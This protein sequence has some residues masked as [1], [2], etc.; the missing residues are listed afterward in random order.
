MDIS[1]VALELSNGDPR[2]PGLRDSLLAALER[3]PACRQDGSRCVTEVLGFLRFVL[4][5]ETC[6]AHTEV[7][8][9]SGAWRHSHFSWELDAPLATWHWLDAFLDRALGPRPR[10]EADPKEEVRRRALKTRL[11]IEACDSGHMPAFRRRLVAAISLDPEVRWLLDRLQPPP[12]G[13]TSDDYT[14]VWQSYATWADLRNDHEDLAVLL[15]FLQRSDAGE[16]APATASGFQG[17]KAH[18]LAMKAGRAG[19]QSICRHA[20]TLCAQAL[21]VESGNNLGA[22]VALQ[23]RLLRGF[24][25]R[26]PHPEIVRAVLGSTHLVQRLDEIDIPHRLLELAESAFAQARREK[27]AESF[28]QEEWL[29]VIAWVIEAQPAF[30]R[31]QWERGWPAILRAKSEWTLHELARASRAEWTALAAP[32][33]LGDFVVVELD[34]AARL[35]VE[36]VEM[37]HCVADYAEECISGRTRIFSLARR[38]TGRRVATVL[39]QSTPRGWQVW[40]ARGRANAPLP[41]DVQDVAKCIPSRIPIAGKQ[42]RD[43]IA[44]LLASLDEG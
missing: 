31:N 38:D 29:P 6:T 30:H 24:G 19:W 5:S 35:V 16:G 22:M 12:E 3:E 14:Q 27:N 25:H 9:S 11:R 44:E 2:L 13:A 41:D 10:G 28:I 42:D 18:F 40:Q 43:G 23:A 36:G 4:D 7:R 1:P 17:L 33:A 34:S 20:R 32:L 26:L 8:A 15:R 39:C 37:A 21:S